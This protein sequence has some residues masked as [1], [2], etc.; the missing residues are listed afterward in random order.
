MADAGVSPEVLKVYVESSAVMKRPTG[1]DIVALK[2][3]KVSD[4]VT[5]LLI[6]RGTEAEK[7]I[8]E[9]RN[10]AVARL[11]SS[12]RTASGG[13]DPESYEFFQYYYLQPRAM[14]SAYERLAPYYYPGFGYG[15]GSFY[16]YRPAFSG[17]AFHPGMPFAH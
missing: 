2:E 9:A 3:H 16:G 15:Y 14:A 10:N 12:R 8:A 17:R 6:K 13:L 4:E 1:A 5:T 11:V 7:S